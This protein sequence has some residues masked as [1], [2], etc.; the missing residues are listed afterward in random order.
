MRKGYSELVETY[1]QLELDAQLC[2]PLYAASRGVT[3]RYTELLHELDLTY[4]QYVTMLALWDAGE[5]LTVGEIGERL[6]LDSGTLTPVLKRLEAAGRV[7]R[8][9]DPEDERRVLVAST[10]E[11]LRL[12]AE[13]AQMPERAWAS[14]GLEPAEG[15]QLRVLLHRLIG[16]LDSAG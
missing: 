11:G 10:A 2:L 4:P 8:T 12:R 5:P 9:R 15:E 6:H 7:T 13:V 14:M 16:G 1:P 3:R